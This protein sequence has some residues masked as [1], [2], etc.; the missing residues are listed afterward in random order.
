[1]ATPWTICAQSSAFIEEVGAPLR[2]E[3]RLVA[4]EDR[5]GNRRQGEVLRAGPLRLDLVARERDGD[6]HLAE[7]EA[8]GGVGGHRHR[9]LGLHVRLAEVD[10]AR[11]ALLQAYRDRG[12]R[13]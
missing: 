2:L 13:L 8:V 7:P 12:L 10:V 11:L 1:A 3:L 6:V 4:R 5:L 9:H